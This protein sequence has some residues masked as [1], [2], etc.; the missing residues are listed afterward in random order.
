[1]PGNI[2]NVPCWP[3]DT[4]L[5]LL[6]DFAVNY[7]APLKPAVKAGKM[8]AMD[9]SDPPSPGDGGS[10]STNSYSPSY[11]TPIDYGTNLW[12]AQ[13]A[14]TSSN[15][16]GT[17]SNSL[18]D[19][20]YEIQYT[21]NLAT[22]T[23]WLS[24]GFVYGSELTNWTALVMTNVSRT[25]NAF[26]RIRSWQDDGSSLP[27]WW[28]MQYFGTNGVDPYGNPLVANTFIATQ[29]VFIPLQTAIPQTN[30]ELPAANKIKALDLTKQFI[31]SRNVPVNFYGQFVDQDGNPLS[32][33]NIKIVIV[34]LSMP[35]PLVPV[36]GSKDI[37]LERNSDAGGR[38]EIHGETGEGFDVGSIQKAGYD[39]EPG[40]RSFGA[41]G[42][43]F[44]SP[45]IFKMWS[46]NIHEKLIT[47]GKSFDIVPDG[48]PY[49]VNLTDDTISESGEGDLK[50]W[51]Q[52]TNQIVPGQL[53]D[54]SARIEV[55]NGGLLEKPLGTA[56]FE[57][58]PDGYVPAFQL[59]GQIKGGQ[60]GDT[61]ER[62]FYLK[63]KNDQEYGQMS[64]G[65]Y[66]PFN[67]QTPGLIRLSY[68]IN[69]SGSRILR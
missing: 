56:M 46:T 58:P 51:I 59:S 22:D 55:I 8:T 14:V 64:I 44:E 53:Y 5:V 10:G 37:H 38:F 60:R 52:Y 54:W 61:G 63:L 40:Q 11:Q 45:V 29:G 36:L 6:D 16:A 1:M 18:A 13:F 67:D 24:G 47:G 42:G 49:F 28:Q 19:I 2:D 7:A 33:V 48:R 32:G 41:V 27:I 68:A 31:E 50:V 69:P 57:A 30:A 39:M 12:I 3:L 65:L 9:S 34:H 21:H 35:D 15:A 26:Y 43:S 62:Q 23:Q 20:L 66:A 4:N 25:N 17:L